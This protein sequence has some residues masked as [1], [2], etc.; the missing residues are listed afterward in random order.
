MAQETLVRGTTFSEPDNRTIVATGWFDAPRQL[1]WDA[2]TTCEHLPKWQGGYEGWTMPVCEMD[3]RPGGKYR[4]G[5][6]GPGEPFEFTG[7]YREITPPERIVQTQVFQGAE[8]ID[9]LKLTDENGGTKL[10]LTAVYPSSE[11]REGAKATGMEDGWAWT[12]ERLD[13]HLRTMM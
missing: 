5:Y 13:E 3:F 1:V 10:T 7:E 6:E 9:T 8:E 12:Y 11:A 2:H 4:Y